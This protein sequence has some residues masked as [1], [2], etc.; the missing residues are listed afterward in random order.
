MGANVE[1]AIPFNH[2]HRRVTSAAVALRMTAIDLFA[3]QS[4]A[5][6]PSLRELR[7]PYRG[8]AFQPRFSPLPIDRANCLQLVVC[9]AWVAP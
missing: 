3:R 1:L 4:L 5:G 8:V 9:L 2:V 7:A 6:G